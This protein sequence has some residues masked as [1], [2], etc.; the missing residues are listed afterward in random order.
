MLTSGDIVDLDLGLPEGRE[1]GFRH[2]AVVVTAQRVLDNA[3]NVVHV[4][5]LTSQLR[6]FAS[7]VELEA[8]PLNGLEVT[9][10]AQCQHIRAV[11][12]GRIRE[13]RGNIGSAALLQIREV[14]G[15]ILDVPA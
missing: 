4:V 2:P 1:A 5:P 12:A 14:L 7:E 10:A 6:G 8:D 15:L 13:S 9:S 3:P 11:V